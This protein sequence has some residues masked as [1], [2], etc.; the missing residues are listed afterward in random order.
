MIF[1]K[2]P[3]DEAPRDEHAEELR[4][5]LAAADLPAEA[6]RTAEK[7]LERLSRTDPSLAEYSIASAYLDCILSLPWNALS[8]ETPDPARA[9]RVLETSHAGL[10]QVKERVLEHLASRTMR[11]HAVP[12]VLVVDDETIARENLRH[13]LTRE[14]YRVETAANGLEALDKVRRWEVDLIVTDLKME[15]MDGLQLLEEARRISPTTR[16]VMVTGFATV[17]TAVSAM[18]A[19]AVH[20][21]S[22]PIEIDELRTTV[23]RLLGERGPAPAV[24]S[25]VLCFVGP[26]GVGKTSVGMA[27]A[28]ALGRS[29]TRMSLADLHDE[30]ELRGHRRT[31]AGAMPGRIIQALRSLS[32]RNPVFMLDEV[33]KIAQDAKGDP[34]AAL[35]EILDPEQNARFVDRYLEIP[36]DLSSVLFIATANSV[37]RLEGPVLDR[38]ELV[39]FSG[40][41]EAEKRDIARRFLVPRQLREHGLTKPCPSFPDATLSAIIRDYTS[42]AGVRGLEREIARLCRK[43]ARRCLQQGGACCEEIGPGEVAGLLGPRRYTHGAALNDPA[44]GLA[45]GLVWSSTGGEVVVVEATRMRGSGRL[46]MTGSLGEVL[47]ESGQIALSHIRSNAARL[48]LDEEFFAG[49][50]IHIHIPA[51]G[52]TKDGPSAGLTICVAL[53]SLLTGRAVRSDTALSGE[54]SLSGRLLPVGGIREKLL[55]AARAGI[56][57]VVL[58][59]ANAAD[60]AALTEPPEELPRVVL[61]RDVDAA[62]SEALTK[63]GAAASAAA[64]DAAGVPHEGR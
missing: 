17:E 48:G 14:G 9:E 27:V 35:L 59:E 8:P 22:K 62:L 29:F 7:E 44:P 57:T 46:L 34:A 37:D 5:R 38:M 61:A 32:V 51:G 16:V 60:V 31:Y 28:E 13:V 2:K 15:Q 50:D 45:A 63:A 1:F 39:P 58:P 52:V 6:R 12:L 25:P 18:K 33:D 64:P 41:S 26:P 24:R 40:Y 49:H 10:G 54:I 3:E 19:G 56:F 23:R 36:F 53:V 42:E 30:A 43:L 55:A 21:L 4:A 20:Y 11:A 47:K